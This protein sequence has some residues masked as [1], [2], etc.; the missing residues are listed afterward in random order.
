ML[1]A[2]AVGTATI[3]VLLTWMFR[4]YSAS[5][6]F[7][8]I[9]SSTTLP[10]GVSG[11]AAQF[12]VSLGASGNESVE[13]YADLVESYDLLRDVAETR[14]VFPEKVD[15]VDS[16]SGNIMDLYDIHEDTPAQTVAK[17]VAR[18]QRDISASPDDPSGLVTLTVKAPWPILA[19]QI[20][21]HI[22]GLVNQFNL[23]ARQSQARSEREFAQTRLK[24][25]RAELDSAEDDLRQ[26]LE[27]NRTFQSSPRLAFEAARLQRHID[28]QQQVFLTV[29][30]AYEQARIDEV[31]DTPVFSTIANPEGSAVP[32]IRLSVVG[33]LGLLL[34]V[35]LGVGVV[36]FQ[37]YLDRR[38]SEDPH[39]VRVFMSALRSAGASYVPGFWR[40][41]S[42][43]S[44]GNSE[45]LL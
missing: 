16:L 27:K 8:P 21:R 36:T 10:S 9:T 26:F 2:V 18:L 32:S 14:Y 4:P 40:R 24:Q 42:R 41:R 17:A 7:M 19:E 29:T 37:A 43:H 25:A 35:I 38:R 33:V 31:R 5:A 45:K 15:G 11:L 34:G 1:V 44:P 3:I 6:V 30:T 23:E 28:V 22:L 12:G 39:D 13:F 20:T